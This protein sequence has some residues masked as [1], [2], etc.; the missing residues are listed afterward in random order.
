MDNSTEIVK[1]PAGIRNKL[2]AATS[3]LLI[4]CIMMVSSTYA[5]FTLSTAPEVKNITTTVAGNGSLEIALMPES[6]LLSGITTGVSSESSADALLTANRTWG[7]I[8]T[9]SDASYGLE[10]VTLNPATLGKTTTTTDEEGNTTTSASAFNPASPLATATYGFDGRIDQILENTS[11]KSMVT[12]AGTAAQGFSGDGYGVRAIGVADSAGTLG[13][14]YGY[15]IDMAFRLN[16]GDAQGAA[17]NLLLQTAAVQRIYDGNETSNATT[18][19]GGS[20]MS[21]T[22][23]SGVDMQKLMPAIRVTFVQNYGNAGEG[24]TPVVLGTAK[25]DT[26]AT[27][28][29]ATAIKAPL[30]LYDANGAALKDGNAVI[31]SGLAKN[32]AAQIS[33]LVWLDGNAVTNSSV[34]A[35]KDLLSKATLNLQFSTN[36]ELKPAGNNTLMGTSNAIQGASTSTVS[37]DV[38]VDNTTVTGT[39]TTEGQT[40]E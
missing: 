9:L 8:V 29:E 34:S 3:M 40:T 27:V 2:M 25:L 38:V 16:T 5:W 28:N 4:S 36:V 37:E 13:D 11:V 24:L 35:S 33:A 19:G 10:Q 7:N 14:T 32:T 18:M 26:T 15:V 21:F 6:G 12:K 17:G 39:Q 1:M 22:K 23:D 20:Y 30:Y 31:L